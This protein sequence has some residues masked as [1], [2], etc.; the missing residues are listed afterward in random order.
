MGAQRGW[1]TIH[2]SEVGAIEKQCEYA[3]RKVAI[4]REV[5]P[6]ALEVLRIGGIDPYGIYADLDGLAASLLLKN[7][8]TAERQGK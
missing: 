1:F 6:A 8:S 4:P 7:P 3:V 5:V 2:G